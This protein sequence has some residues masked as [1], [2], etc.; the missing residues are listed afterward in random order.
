MR[1]NISVF[2]ELIITLSVPFRGAFSFIS[3]FHTSRFFEFFP[4]QWLPVHIHKPRVS[5]KCLFSILPCTISV[6]AAKILFLSFSPVCLSSNFPPGF[7]SV[8]YSYVPF[9][10]YPTV[11]SLYYLPTC[12]FCIIVQCNITVLSF[13]ISVVHCPTMYC[14]CIV[15]QC[16]V[17]VLFSCVPRLY[18]PPMFPFCIIL[19][20]AASVLCS[21][22]PFPH[23]PPM[24][25][26]L[27]I[28]LPCIL[29]LY[30]FRTYSVSFP[31]A[32]LSRLL[33]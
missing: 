10:Y 32:R 5:K 6:L 9:L 4:D 3:F 29:P 26:L 15:T 8:L 14:F 16:K 17:S 20:C 1:C 2:T 7:G 28:N 21:H 12:L 31:D 18:Y 27:C 19:S 11:Y 24:Y 25:H 13:H 33:W 22:L 30:Y 23:Y